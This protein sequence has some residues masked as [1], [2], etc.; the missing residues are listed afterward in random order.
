MLFIEMHCNY[1]LPSL[2][3]NAPA[4]STIGWRLGLGCARM[5]SWHA[6]EH[7]HTCT[8]VLPR[9][10]GQTRK[11]LWCTCLRACSS[12]QQWWRPR[13]HTPSATLQDTHQQ[14]IAKVSPRPYTRLAQAGTSEGSQ[15]MVSES[16]G[17]GV[18]WLFRVAGIGVFLVFFFP[19]TGTCRGGACPRLA[20]PRAGG[21]VFAGGAHRRICRGLARTPSQP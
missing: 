18:S 15:C 14:R 5:Q 6:T 8:L 19:A 13:A 2:A 9:T 21:R 12:V 10:E 16:S 1:G 17:A 20:G 7:F 4:K 11:P 3:G